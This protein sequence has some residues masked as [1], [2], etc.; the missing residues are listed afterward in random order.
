MEPLDNVD[1][2]ILKHLQIN[3]KIT[4]KELASL[5]N[6]TISPIYERI[7]RLETL[8][9]IQQ[10]VAILN[11]ALLEKRFTTMCQVSLRNHD[12]YFIERF[13]HEI[14]LLEEV[15]ECYHVSGQVDFVL[16]IAIASPEEYH[17]FVKNKLSKIE[18]IGTL[19]SAFI[20][21]EIKYTHAFKL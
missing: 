15:Q 8:N 12:E 10:Y 11:R 7:K 13:E 6:L 4:T 21:K 3:A 9:Y 5:L 1:K 19:N 2:A 14:Q 20:L 17:L 18:N 16:K